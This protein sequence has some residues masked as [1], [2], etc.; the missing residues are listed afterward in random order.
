MPFFE[1]AERILPAFRL[2]EGNTGALLSSA[3]RKENTTG[4]RIRAKN[5]IGEKREETI[6]MPTKKK[7]K[8]RKTASEFEL[9]IRRAKR[10]LRNF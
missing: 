10:F 6:I 2:E 9:A 3:N 5:K 1:F 8:K 7:Y 4:Q